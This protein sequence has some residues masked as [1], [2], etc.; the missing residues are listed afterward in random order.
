MMSLDLDTGV[1]LVYIGLGWNSVAELGK[2]CVLQV[3]IF[4]L[5][6]NA[7]PRRVWRWQ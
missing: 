5:I 4:F 2:Q 3:M 7:G 1:E 6:S